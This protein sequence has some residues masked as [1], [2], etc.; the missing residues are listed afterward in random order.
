MLIPVQGTSRSQ[1]HLGR[2][3]FLK[4]FEFNSQILMSGSLVAA[5]SPTATTGLLFVKG[6]HTAVK[7]LLP[8]SSLPADF[9]KVREIDDKLCQTACM[10]IDVSIQLILITA[11]NL[12]YQV[13]CPL[14][15]ALCYDSYQ[16]VP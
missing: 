1:Q 14:T 13:S 8:R 2:L 9:D 10:F 6:A 4:V 3:H 7:K 11:H 16:S 15:T 12:D 5:G